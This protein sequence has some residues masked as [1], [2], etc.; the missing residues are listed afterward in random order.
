M[1]RSIRAAMTYWTAAQSWRR[2]PR[3]V[4]TESSG[5]GAEQALDYGTDSG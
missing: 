4:G 3:F 1:T 5:D 2:Q